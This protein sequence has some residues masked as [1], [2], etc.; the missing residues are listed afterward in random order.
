M[1]R[2]PKITNLKYVRSTR[3]EARDEGPR[4]IP[5]DGKSRYDMQIDYYLELAAK[6]LDVST[7]NFQSPPP[8][9]GRV[10]Y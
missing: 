6:A 3:P 1:Q 9:K 7:R 2:T 5:L 4:L 8:K 10:K